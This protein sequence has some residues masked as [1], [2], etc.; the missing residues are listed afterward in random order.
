MGKIVFMGTPDFAAPC[1]TA[2]MKSQDLVGVV[3]QPD[4]PAGR[5]KRLRESPVKRLARSAGIP[6]IQP[7]RIREEAAIQAL[8]AWDADLHVVAAYGQILPQSVLNIPKQGTI[9]VHA[10]LLPRW[11]GAA[12]IQA[13]ILA[14]DRESGVTIMLV[15]AGLDTGPTLAKRSLP[16]AIDET[17]QSLHDKLSLLGAEL[18]GETLPRYLNGDI[19]PQAQDDSLASYAPQLKKGEGEID[20]T[21]SAS[22]ID[23]LVRAFTPWPGTYTYWKGA[24]LRILAGRSGEGVAEAGRVVLSGGSLAIGAGQGLYFPTTLQLAGKRRLPVSDFLN[25]YREFAGARLGA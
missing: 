11:R 20:W 9:N 7:R 6:I 8:R 23:R 19:E 18:L 5:N 3:T 25:G 15:D 4:R 12:P 21:C 16:L 14:G 17:G 2:L 10:S 22:A 24:Q 13:A 1:L